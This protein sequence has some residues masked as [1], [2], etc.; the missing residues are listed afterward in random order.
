M[1]RTVYWVLNIT[2]AFLTSLTVA[3]YLIPKIYLPPIVN[4]PRLPIPR[5]RSVSLVELK[6]N[7]DPMIVRI[8]Q[9]KET[10]G[11]NIYRDDERLSYAVAITSDGWVAAADWGILSGSKLVA[12]NGNNQILPIIDKKTDPA[13]GVVFLKVSSE[14]FPSADFAPN[15][16]IG[17]RLI[18]LGDSAEFV[19]VKSLYSV[20]LGKNNHLFSTAV[21]PYFGEIDSIF[22]EG[23]PL[24]DLEGKLAGFAAP[25]VAPDLFVP[26]RYINGRLN[27]IFTRKSNKRLSL[28]YLD[29]ARWPTNSGLTTGARLMESRSGLVKG[30]IIAAVNGVPLSLKNNLSE[31]LIG[32][33]SGSNI[34]L[35]IVSGK[36]IRKTQVILP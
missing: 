33:R 35:E 1:I 31:L 18:L 19:E 2:V 28:D 20:R 17:D 8:Y 25:R 21:F 32:L 24:F 23:A 5:G 27:E 30:E 4:N 11:L 3:L 12:V 9:S 29:L 34:D 7:L 14:S 16:A 10:R 13:S 15:L 26:S 36:N 22:G 6:K